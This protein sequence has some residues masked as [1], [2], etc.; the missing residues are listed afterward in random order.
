MQTRSMGTS[1]AYD[2]SRFAPSRQAV[3][4][5]PKLVVTDP[6]V[7]ARAHARTMYAIKVIAGLLVLAS[8]VVAMLYSRATITELNTE[9]NTQQKLLRDLQ[10]E[11]VRLSAELESQVSMR[12]L[13]EYATQKLGM[14]Q[15]DKSQVTYVDL[16]QGDRIELTNTSLKP[17]LMER[18]KLAITNVKALLEKD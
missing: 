16:N 15:L 7:K 4:R 8:V 10:S 11:Q 9:I 2:L 6:G 17:T 12:N 1:A 18:L 3:S 5:R 14:S 13:E